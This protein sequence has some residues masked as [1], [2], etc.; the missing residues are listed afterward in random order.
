MKDKSELHFLGVDGGGTQNKAVILDEEGKFLGQGEGGGVNYQVVGI[1]AF[2]KNLKDS[3]IQAR[4]EAKTK[5]PFT[6]AV[7]GLAGCNSTSDHKILS[8]VLKENFNNLFPA[9]LL[10]NDTRVALRSGTD[11]SFGV[12]VIAGTGSNIYGRNSEGEEALAGGLDYFLADE[13]S[14]YDIGRHVLRAAVRSFDGRDG[15]S[16]LEKLVVEKL[17]V[18]TMREAVDKIYQPVFNKTSVASFAPLAEQA[19]NLGDQ[20]AKEILLAAG[21]ELYLGV[22][23]VVKKLKM[24]DEGFDLVMAGSVF[25]NKIIT[26]KFQREVKEFIPGVRFTFPKITPA[27]AAALL[28]RQ[29]YTSCT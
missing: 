24:R 27:H 22:K 6:F 25:N 7:F 17:D 18:P 29:V 1:S 12:V 14:A 15:R 28:G 23:A 16:V 3:I 9:F 26:E 5:S 21:H 2:K 8:D 13:G 4:K 10:V 11:E 20:K 19:A